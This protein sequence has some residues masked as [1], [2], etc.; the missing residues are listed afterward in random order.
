[1]TNLSK[2]SDKVLLERFMIALAANRNPYDESAVFLL[3]IG[4]L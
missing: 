4:D 2:I 1:M 3:E